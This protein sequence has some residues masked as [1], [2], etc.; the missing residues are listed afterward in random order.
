MIVFLV[1]LW[2]SNIAILLGLE[3]DAETASQRAVADGLP[4]NEEPY[5]PPRDTRKW[6]EE[7]RPRMREPAHAPP[8]GGTAAFARGPRC[9]PKS[10]GQHPDSFCVR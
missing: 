10:F 4:S 2:I 7:D 8:T 3:F 6:D 9:C 1:W 5:V